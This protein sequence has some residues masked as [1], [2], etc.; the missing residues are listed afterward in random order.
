MCTF[1]LLHSQRE[2][3]ALPAYLRFGHLEE[4]AGYALGVGVIPAS[5]TSFGNFT[6]HLFLT[7]FTN[8]AKKKTAERG[9]NTEEAQTRPDVV[10]SEETATAGITYSENRISDLEEVQ[11]A[12]LS[13]VEFMALD[14]A[15]NGE[16]LHIA[17][18]RGYLKQFEPEVPR[19][20]GNENGIGN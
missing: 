3:L 8:M 9:T 11:Q 7:K 18:N 14:G 20:R 12:V 16:R 6:V 17:R 1:P 2:G 5:A 13:P 4:P 19:P 10:L 15:I